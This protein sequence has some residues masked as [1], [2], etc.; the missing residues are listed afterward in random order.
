[1]L[2]SLQI[3]IITYQRPQ[4]LQAL[5]TSLSGQQLDAGLEVSICIVDNACDDKTRAIAGEY[6]ENPYP[7]TV[8]KEPKRGIVYA[9]NRTVEHFLTGDCDALVF[10]DD[11][12]WTGDEYWLMNLIKARQQTNADIVTSDVISVPETEEIAWTK[13]AMGRDKAAAD[14]SPIKRFYTGNVLITR[15]VLEAIR[16]A[17]DERFALTGSSDLHFAMMCAQGGFR[18]VYTDKAPVYETFPNT[19]ANFKWF[20]MRGFRNGSGATRSALYRSRGGQGEGRGHSS[21]RIGKTVFL[22]VVMACA[23]FAKGCY[24]AARSI[25]TWDKGMFANAVMRWGASIGTIMGLFGIQYEEYKT[26]HGK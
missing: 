6:N 24:M 22:C 4:G 14:L 26:I 3:S 20:F 12:E 1:M 10:V 19:R 5:L 2:K 8:L 7:V 15:P 21:V 13:N 25:V 18:A 17:F 16:P 23:R 11:D 9:R